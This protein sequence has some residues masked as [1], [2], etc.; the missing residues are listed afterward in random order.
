[1]LPMNQPPSTGQTC[2]ACQTTKIIRHLPREVE[3]RLDYEDIIPPGEPDSPLQRVAILRI[4][5]EREYRC[6]ECGYQW[7]ETLVTESQK[8]V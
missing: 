6:A 2:P 1:M 4:T 8:H 7:W 5:Y 3:R